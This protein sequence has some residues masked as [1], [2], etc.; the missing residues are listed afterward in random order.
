MEQPLYVIDFDGVLYDQHDT[1]KVYPEAIEVIKYLRHQGKILTIAT[2]RNEME[3][4]EMIEILKSVHIYDMFEAIIY[5][6]CPKP[7]HI[8]QILNKFKVK[9]PD[10]I[11][12]PTLYDDFDVNIQDIRKVGYKGVLID[13][14]YG[15]RFMDI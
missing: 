6:S 14:K 3:A 15:L 7:W 4:S 2:R 8:N 9:Y 1:R 12:H 10:I 11:F 5:N 13:N